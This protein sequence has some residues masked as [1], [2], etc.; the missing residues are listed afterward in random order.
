MDKGK[1]IIEALNDYI[2]F[3]WNY[4]QGLE[5]QIEDLECKLIDAGV[6]PDDEDNSSEDEP[7]IIKN[8]VGRS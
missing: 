5:A 1:I 2:G 7:V 6:D 4:S 8:Q 3:L